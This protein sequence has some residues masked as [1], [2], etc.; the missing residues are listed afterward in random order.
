MGINT[1]NLSTKAKSNILYVAFAFVAVVT[2]VMVLH[3]SIRS[4]VARQ[5]QNN[6]A[7][8]LIGLNNTLNEHYNGFGVSNDLLIHSAEC[9][10]AQMG[11]IE[12]I[13]S[14]F[15]QIG[16]YLLP[17]WS[18]G[19]N[20]Q[21]N[22]NAFCKAVARGLNGS[23]F[24]I[25]QKN[26]KDYVRIATTIVNS[27]GNLAVGTKLDDPEVMRTIEAGEE[28]FASTVILGVSYVA[29]YKPLYING[30]LKGIYFTGQE[31][32]KIQ[33]Q[34]ATLNSHNIIDDGFT[35]WSSD[36]ENRCYEG[37]WGKMTDDIYKEMLRNKD[38][39]PHHTS[40]QYDGLNY[41]MTYIHNNNTKSFVSLVYPS[42]SK[43]NGVKSTVLSLALVI[44]VIIALMMIASNTLNNSILSAVGGEPREVQ[45]LVNRIAQ[46]DLRISQNSAK[47]ATGILKS[48]YE[49]TGS[50]RDILEKI[51][52]GANAL[53]VSSSEINRATQTLSQN[54]SE[55]AA[56]SENIVQ[57][58][59]DI[60]YE[61]NSNANLASRAD[62]ITQKVTTDIKQIK[63]AQD[64]TYNAVMDIT[65]K[66]NI[67]NDIAAQ[68]NI[69][70]LNAA[71]E[72]ARAGEYGKGFAVVASEIRKLAEKSRTSAAD[73]V[74]GANASVQA[75]AKSTQLIAS[76]LPEIDECASL[77]ERVGN[78]AK[79]QRST[80][81]EI[82]TSVKELNGA[83]Q[84]N[85]A[86]TEE[87]AVS[88][89][90]LNGQAGLFR[91]SSAVFKF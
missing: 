7:S 69:L 72:A 10:L 6:I 62:V 50:L 44:L 74:A 53:Q 58:I 75:T 43:Y 90:E 11:G 83:I 76:I 37:K 29:S 79:S 57:S 64:E 5:I 8:D 25:F 24:T 20:V 3:F 77:I 48:S 80:I 89:E 21:Q 49:M 65:A 12:E 34:N 23:H 45:L 17:K 71:V 84:G 30:E 86:A 91:E 41:D 56:T 46:G 78:S 14:Q 26:G 67:I 28:F 36:T 82:D 4:L 70:A 52:D 9:A 15:V 33:A 81:E 13:K 32:S 16:S 87:L 51:N 55:Q 73:I 31:E 18:V 22:N 85:A 27:D 63:D 38:E 47:S 88:A 66:I 60:A 1:Q 68:T 19:G 39:A 2:L 61:V 40:F 42:T 35:L 59:A 54:A